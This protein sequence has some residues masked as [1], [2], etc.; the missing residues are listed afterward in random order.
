MIRYALICHAC[1][2]EFE[3]WF[4][5][6]DTFETQRDKGQVACTHCHG[7]HVDRAIMAPAIRGTHTS[8]PPDPHKVFGKLAAKA[9]QHV[10]ENFQYVGDGF[11][12]QARAMHYGETKHQPIWGKTTAEERQSLREEG[13]T[14]EPLHPAMTP[15]PPIEKAKLN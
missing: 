4:A 3:G 8:E 10:S 14:A 11:A 2:S 7:T 13:I 1:E 5:S 15:T 9:R 6:S 12:T